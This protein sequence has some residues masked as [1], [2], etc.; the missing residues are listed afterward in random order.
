MTTKHHFIARWV[1][2]ASLSLAVS[3]VAQYTTADNDSSDFFVPL[4]QGLGLPAWRV[5]EPFIS[6]WIQHSVI[7]YSTSAGRTIAFDIAYNQR[8]APQASGTFGFGPSWQCSWLS[9]IDYTIEQD[10]ELG[11]PWGLAP[12]ISPQL[13]APLGGVRVYE[14]DDNTPEYNTYSKMLAGHVGNSCGTSFTITYPD[15]SKHFY[16]DRA[17]PCP[18]YVLDCSL[19]NF[20][21]YIRD[22]QGRQINFYY[23][24]N[25]GAFLLQKVVDYDNRTNLF[26]YDTTFSNQV[27]QIIDPYNRTNRFEYGQGGRLTNIVNAEGM[28]CSFVYNSQGVIT[29][30]V[31]FYGNTTFRPTSNT[32]SGNVVKRSLEVAEPDGRKHL[33]IY[34]DQSSKLSSNSMTELLPCS[35]PSNQLPN[36]S[37]FTNTF[38]NTWMDARNSF[39]WSPRCY[40]QLSTNYT[41]SGDVNNLTLADYDLAN[42]KHWLIVLNN[43]VRYLGNTLSMER[44]S[45]ADGTTQGQKQW[46][47]Y[48]GKPGVV[49]TNCS[50]QT[51]TNYYYQGTGAA[52]SIVGVILDDG[53]TRYTYREYT[54]WGLPL[55]SVTTYSAAGGVATKT[56]TFA[57]TNDIDLLYSRGPSSEILSSN[58]FNSTHQVLTNYD[59]LNQPA[60]YVYNSLGQLKYSVSRAGLTTTNIYYASGLYSN[61][62]QQVV[63]MEIGRSRTVTYTNALVATFADERGVTTTNTYDNLERLLSVSDGRGN[64][65]YRFTNMSPV[66]TVDRMG[67]G[68]RYGHDG[69]GRLI[70]Q[71]GPL[72]RTNRLGYY[73]W[74]GLAFTTNALGQS[75][76][77]IYDN[78]GR[79]I[80]TLA[81]DGQGTTNRYDSSG[82]LLSTVDSV[83]VVVNNYFNNQGLLCAVSNAYGR[84]SFATY[85]A[86]DRV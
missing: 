37:P 45:S 29:N 86:R 76:Q 7:R 56:N 67:F 1:A 5:S 60:I 4:G 65:T 68:T 22:P 43:G 6:L 46:F 12:G 33:F 34:R 30:M 11:T 53:T 49:A 35:Y 13:V 28:A 36:T 38:D 23:S 31:S 61:F 64:I 81:P 72:N 48:G 42:L 57:Y 54:Q 41:Q 50:S 14:P 44:G 3:G 63:E 79:K 25:T 66:E 8:G 27:S 77:N 70:W 19:R 58:F 82:N 51:V 73:S 21:T 24:T 83:G 78:L 84:V 59:S 55:K 20:I 18:N 85:D 10:P 15:G 69:S 75:V 40:A 52:P 62:L 71:T 47:D 74:G 17:C 80:V 26:I 16:S 2:A 32:N 9:Y 39:Y